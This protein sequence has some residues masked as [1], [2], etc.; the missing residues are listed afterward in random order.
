[1][2]Y[3]YEAEPYFALD[4]EWEKIYT[5]YNEVEAHLIRG[6]LE[7]EG[8][9]CRLQSRRI[10]QFP[11]TVSGLGAIDIYVLAEEAARSKRLI[12]MVYEAT[13]G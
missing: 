12:F 5:T 7:G 6:C 9:T 3:S 11:L 2:D 13:S 8:I 1:M 10:P 4:E